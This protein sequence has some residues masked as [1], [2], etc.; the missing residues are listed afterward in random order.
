MYEKSCSHEW[1]LGGPSELYL[2]CWSQP[3]C[4]LPLVE[5]G[6]LFASFPQRAASQRAGFGTQQSGKTRPYGFQYSSCWLP[7]PSGSGGSCLAG[8]YLTGST[9]RSKGRRVRSRLH[10]RLARLLLLAWHTFRWRPRHQGEGIIGGGRCE[11]GG[12]RAPPRG[13]L[14]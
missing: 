9:R 14:D 5:S 13:P 10:R 1:V 11:R 6:S 7:P 8:A 12:G 4:C 3:P 2:G